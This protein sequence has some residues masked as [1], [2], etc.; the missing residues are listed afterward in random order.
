MPGENAQY[1]VCT[2][3]SSFLV[4]NCYGPS[5]TAPKP[6]TSC[7][8]TFVNPGGQGSCLVNW[9]SCSDGKVY[10]LSC[11]NMSCYCLVDGAAAVTLEPLA[12]C[13]ESKS[14]INSLCGWQLN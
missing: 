4:W 2:Q 11:V 9:L 14:A 10:S 5:P 8:Q 12:T 13:P 3:E 1:C 7:S 6:Q